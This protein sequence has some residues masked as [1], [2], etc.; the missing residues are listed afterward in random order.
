M[1]SW[2]FEW[3][4]GK[5]S[6]LHLPTIIDII[7]FGMNIVYR[8]KIEFKSLEPSQT[9]SRHLSTVRRT[10]LSSTLDE[11]LA[12]GADSVI[13]VILPSSVMAKCNELILQALK[14]HGLPADNEPVMVALKGSLLDE[15]IDRAREK[16]EDGDY[17]VPVFWH[18]DAITAWQQIDRRI[19][20]WVVV[21]PTIINPYYFEI[22]PY[23]IHKLERT[24]FSGRFDLSMPPIKLVLRPERPILSLSFPVA[25]LGRRLKMSLQLS[26]S[27]YQK[28]PF[29]SLV[30]IRKSPHSYHQ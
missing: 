9:F 18:I 7:F 2:T 14:D 5:W 1:D 6:K 10:S 17:D 23:P 24:R 25:P 29:Q 8:Q 19:D 15:W 20:E 11:V 12:S 26:R 22:N 21:F 27:G 16:A 4:G 30:H 3:Q 13:P 28:F